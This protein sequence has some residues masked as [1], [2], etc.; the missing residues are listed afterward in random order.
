MSGSG[1]G[2]FLYKFRFRLALVYFATLNLSVG[3]LPVRR[4]L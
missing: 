2:L 1:F 4:T 3:D